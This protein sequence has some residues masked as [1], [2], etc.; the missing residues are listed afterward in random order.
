VLNETASRRFGFASPEAAIGQTILGPGTTWSAPASVAAVVPDFLLNTAE[1]RIKPTAY[2]PFTA[3][4][5]G[6]NLLFLELTRR[7]IPE[8]LGGIEHLWATLHPNEPLRR[9]FLDAYIQ[10][11]YLGVLRQADLLA[12]FSGLAIVLSALGLA[13]LAA[14]ATERRVKEIG[15][16]KA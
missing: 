5:R 11:L 9:Y 1:P 14:S 7:R 8:T 4:I 2:F 3:N 6:D 13:G 12:I 15:V 16:R 10:G